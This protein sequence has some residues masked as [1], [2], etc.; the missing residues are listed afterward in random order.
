MNMRLRKLCGF[1]QTSSEAAALVL[2]K[3]F[4]LLARTVRL[5]ERA[6]QLEHC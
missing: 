6:D 1:Y 5:L 3:R 4:R 2:G